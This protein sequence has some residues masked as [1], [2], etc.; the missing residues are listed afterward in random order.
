MVYIQNLCFDSKLC[1]EFVNDKNM[2]MNKDNLYSVIYQDIQDA[3]AEIQQLT[4]DQHLCAIGLGMVEDF[5]G[6]FYVG[7]TLEQLKTFEDV[8][9]AWWISEWSCSST[10]NNRVHDAIT[11]LYQDLGEDYTDEQYS[12]L[13]AHYQKTIIQALQDLRTQGKLKNQQGEEIIVIIQYADSS[14]EDFEDISFPQINPEFLVPL[15][16]NRFQKKAGE[17]LYDYLLEKSAS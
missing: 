3:F 5:C 7:C 8:Y 14:D 1:I 15:F 16:E 9:E 4:Q 6:F 17:N 13:Q 11:A 10:A 12:E 2:M